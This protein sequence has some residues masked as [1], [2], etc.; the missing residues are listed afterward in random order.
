MSRH[1]RRPNL[2]FLDTYMD[3][4]LSN[5]QNTSVMLLGSCHKFRRVAAHCNAARGEVCLALLVSVVIEFAV[6]SPA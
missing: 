4:S 3:R 6:M 5:F 2:D 1:L